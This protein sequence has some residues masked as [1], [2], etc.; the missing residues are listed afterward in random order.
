MKI[1]AK[2]QVTVQCQTKVDFTLGKKL[3]VETDNGIGFQIQEKD[4]N[5]VIAL[6]KPYYAY[7]KKNKEIIITNEIKTKEK[8][9]KPIGQVENVKDY[10]NWS[11]ISRLLAGNPS[12]ITKNQISRKNLAKVQELLDFVNDWVL[13]NK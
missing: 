2:N 11:E 12:T 1:E 13:K 8:V 4:Q 9:F 6:N 5:V 7:V 3:K 10:L